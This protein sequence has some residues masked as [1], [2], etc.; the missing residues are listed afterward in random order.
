MIWGY[1]SGAVIELVNTIFLFITVYTTIFFVYAGA[2]FIR[3][4]LKIATSISEFSAVIIMFLAVYT[5]GKIFVSLLKAVLKQGADHSGLSHLCGIVL[6]AIRGWLQSGF[7]MVV[8]MVAPFAGLQESIYESRFGQD[9]L[10][11]NTK[12]YA[13]TV[14]RVMQLNE[15]NGINP[16]KVVETLSKQKDFSIKILDFDLKNKRDRRSNKDFLE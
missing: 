16:D 11:S 3:S 10:V 4:Y 2:A 7:I 6:G 12:A 8:F 13:D 9:I 5:T 1:V 14:N 15:N